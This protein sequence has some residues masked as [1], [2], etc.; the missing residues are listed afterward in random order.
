MQQTRHGH[1]GASLLILVL[2]RPRGMSVTARYKKEILR[3]KT[4]LRQRKP[5]FLSNVAIL[6]RDL[7]NYPRAYHWWR[8]AAAGGDGD[9]F[10][11]VGYC[12]QYG[13]GVRA[14]PESAKEA[15]EGAIVSYY[16][17]EYTAE[18]ARYHLALLSVDHFGSAGTRRAV[19]LLR[20]AARDQDYPEAAYLLQALTTGTAQR[21]CR[22]RRGLRKK[23]GAQVACPQHP[24][25]GRRRVAI[26][27]TAGGPTRG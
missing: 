27:R 25:P 19:A 9:S 6:Y 14:N 11:D 26:V 24:A 7:G 12:L 4:R 17:A 1:P 5:V 2:D 16:I 20:E 8:K 21:A 3:L 10:V 22:C 13:I 18:E 23:I 15:Y